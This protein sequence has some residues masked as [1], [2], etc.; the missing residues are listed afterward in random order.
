MTPEAVDVLQQWQ[1][2]Q[3]AGRVSLFTR[4]FRDVRLGKIAILHLPNHEGEINA[5]SMS[6]IIAAFD[7]YR[8]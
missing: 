6:I 8:D 5:Q 2:R 3:S 1:T 7:N 4:Y